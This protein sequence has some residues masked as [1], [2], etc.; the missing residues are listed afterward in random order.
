MIAIVIV[1]GGES[2]VRSYKYYARVI[3][4]RLARGYLT[5]GPGLYAAPR[6]FR[7]GQGFSPD[8]LGQALRRA[9]YVESEAGDV[10]N[11]SFNR[12]DLVVEIR[13]GFV[14]GTTRPRIV[15]ISFTESNRIAEITG[16]D[17]SMESFALEPEVLT[18]DY[19]TKAGRN[20]ALAYSEIPP[21]L[22]HAIL[23]IEDRR[24]FDHSGIDLWGL[25]RALLRNAGEDRPGQGGSTITQQLVKNT[26][27]S[28][29]RTLR[30]KYAEAMLAVALE[31]RV[32]KQDIFALYCNG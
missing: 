26:Y 29:E 28:P 14:D 23:S 8:E 9:G 32:S 21:V 15:R 22:V 10:W 5:S 2:L 4:A 7:T 25:T 1:A 31:R 3:D 18:N 13:P 11:G 24:F 19:S 17:V 27:L 16:D 12:K 30:R 6:S 20:K